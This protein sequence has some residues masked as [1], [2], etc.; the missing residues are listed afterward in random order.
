MAAE[1]LDL[2]ASVIDRFAVLE[3]ALNR[4]LSHAHPIIPSTSSELPL[5]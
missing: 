2:D 3:E 5:R 4:I 1:S